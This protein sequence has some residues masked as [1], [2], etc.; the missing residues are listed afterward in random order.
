M[1]C[2]LKA[3]SAE[4]WLTEQ[5]IEGQVDPSPIFNKVRRT[6]GRVTQQN[7]FEKSSELKSNLQGQKNTLTDVGYSNTFSVEVTQNIMLFAK[8]VL[9]NNVDNLIDLEITTV[10]FD[11]VL[12]QI[13]DSALGFID[14]SAG[15]WIFIKG[16]SIAELNKPYYVMD[17]IDDGTLQVVDVA[18]TA[19]AGDLI[20]VAGSM[21]RSGNT[22]HMLT[23][24]GRDEHTGA[25]DGLDYKTQIDAV[26]DTL[27][28]SVPQTGL[29]TGSSTLIAATQLD[30]DLQPIAGQTDAP[31]DDSNVLG[32]AMDFKGFYPN[33]TAQDN[34]FADVTIDIIRNTGVQSVAGKLGAKC[35]AQDVIGIT[36]TLTSLRRAVD[37]AA[38]ESKYDNSERFSLSF[39]FEWED[40]KFLMITMR[41]MI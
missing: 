2:A 39:G 14:V 21:L 3:S 5:A 24:Q 41:Q 32:A 28:I 4:V 25:T 27:N 16:S 35:V 15:Q 38:E 36:G 6:D 18:V 7:T 13:T 34:N 40:G 19:G 20:G 23:V 17:K 12:N 30:N 31:V 1:S 8:S 22:A 26:V 33:Q 29:L 9:M 37:P 10:A 11:A